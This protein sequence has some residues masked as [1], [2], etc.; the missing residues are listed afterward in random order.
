MATVTTEIRPTTAAE[1]RQKAGHLILQH[2][3]EVGRDVGIEAPRIDWPR[4]E[5]LD[6]NGF[7]LAVAAWDGDRMAGYFVGVLNNHTHDRDDV[8]LQSDRLFDGIVDSDSFFVS[9][10]YRKSGLARRLLQ[11]AEEIARAR[12]AR[13]LLMSAPAGERLERMLQGM[14]DYRHR[15]TVFCKELG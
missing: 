6:Q 2:W 15:E 13:H 5:L 7:L 4:L 9:E 3:S 10:G 11:E 1:L 12:G 8:C 14:H